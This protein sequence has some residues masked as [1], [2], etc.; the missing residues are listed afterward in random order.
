MCNYLELF[1]WPMT[2]FI[3]SLPCDH[4]H[5]SAIC[6]WL[7]GNAANKY[8]CTLVH[9]KLSLNVP[10]LYYC[11]YMYTLTLRV[12]IHIHMYMYTHP[13]MYVHVQCTHSPGMC[14]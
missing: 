2:P 5:P 11:V 12:H 3:I 8:Y 13:I 6:L 7:L 9:T 14:M 4:P 10:T 1:C